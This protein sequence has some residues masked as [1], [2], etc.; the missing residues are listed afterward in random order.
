[1]LPEMSPD[2]GQVELRVVRAADD[3]VALSCRVSPP[4]RIAIEAVV[5]EAFARTPIEAP[6]SRDVPRRPWYSD[7]LAWSLFV[8]GAAAIAGGLVLGQVHGTPST[9]EAAAW[10]LLAGGAGGATTGLVLFFV[11]RESGA[12]RSAADRR[13][14]ASIGVAV[15]T[16]F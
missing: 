1:M 13:R 14:A 5:S 15:T 12:D 6:G 16:Q 2:A 9:A 8:G 11:P 7:G 10:A 4:E 3:A